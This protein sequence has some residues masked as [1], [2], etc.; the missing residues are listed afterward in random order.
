MNKVKTKIGNFL[1]SKEGTD[2]E[3]IKIESVSNNWNMKVSSF[4]SQF[5][6]FEY[7][8]KEESTKPYF[9]AYINLMYMTANMMPDL[10]FL[11]EYMK[12]YNELVARSNKNEEPTEE[13]D[14]ADIEAAKES[15]EMQ[16]EIE[17]KE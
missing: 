1:V 13:Q 2:I 5:K 15:Y 3:R 14:K 17:N 10:K 12:I 7:L 4:N 6:F 16:K 8:L 11:E 9:E